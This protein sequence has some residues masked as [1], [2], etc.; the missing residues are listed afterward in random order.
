[1][2]L[3]STKECIK[4]KQV[5]F[6]HNPRDRKKESSRFLTEADYA[7][8]SAND[9]IESRHFK[10][11][12]IAAYD[13]ME[14]AAKALLALRGIKPKMHKCVFLFL[15]Q[16]FVDRKLMKKQEI[17]V[18]ESAHIARLQAHYIIGSKV[19]ESRA[20]SILESAISFTEKIKSVIDRMK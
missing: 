18:I 20:K 5:E 16:E 6:I 3:R 15:K 13:S 7:L 9:F 19:S 10:Y 2:V 12:V 11:S 17:D 4:K 8:K 1:M 14:S